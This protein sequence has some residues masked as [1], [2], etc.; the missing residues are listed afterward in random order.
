MI[1]QNNILNIKLM[2]SCCLLRIS[3]ANSAAIVKLQSF[4]DIEISLH[5]QDRYYM[6]LC[7][8]KMRGVKRDERN[9]IIYNIFIYIITIYLVR[10][11]LKIGKRAKNNCITA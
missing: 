5:C 9:F 8:F 7:S 6:Q 10:K 11:A 2:Y 4:S 3:S 1:Y